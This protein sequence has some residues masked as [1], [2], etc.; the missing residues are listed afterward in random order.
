[1]ETEAVATAVAAA[2]PAPAESPAGADSVAGNGTTSVVGHKGKK[3]LRKKVDSSGR[4]KIR[5]VM[6][7]SK[8][9]SGAKD[10]QSAEEERQRRRATMAREAEARRAAQAA[11][12]ASAAEAASGPLPCPGPAQAGPAVGDF[13]VL[14]VSSGSED[15]V[16][17]TAVVVPTRLVTP[18]HAVPKATWVPPQT[19]HHLGI[20]AL[21]PFHHHGAPPGRGGGAVA[22][23]P[24]LVGQSAPARAWGTAAAPDTD[25]EIDEIIK[26][27]CHAR[28]SHIDEAENVK[29]ADGRVLVNYNHPADEDPIYLTPLLAKVIKPH[30]I[31]GLRFLWDNIVE[32]VAELDSGA[33]LGCI[34]AHAMGLGKTLQ[35]VSFVQTFCLRTHNPHRRVVIL[36]PVNTLENWVDEFKK[37]APPP[38]NV[39]LWP[40]NDQ[41]KSWK[42][43]HATIMKWRKEG[44]VLLMGY[45]M[46]RMMVQPTVREA[47]KEVTRRR[48]MGE[49]HVI[50]LEEEDTVETE[51]SNV[52]KALFSPDLVVCDE[53]HRIKN[54]GATI[55]TVLK[56]LETRRRVVLTGYPLQNN[57]EE[58]WCMVDFVR[59]NFL[60]TLAE[61]NNMF[62]IPIKNGSCY[63]STP[64]DVKLMKERA[65]VLHHNLEG[66]V[67]RRDHS[68]LKA[69]L[70]TKHE[71]VIGTRLGELQYE[72]YTDLMQR[73]R[74]G[75]VAGNLFK[76][77]TACAKIW[78]HPDL[79]HTSGKTRGKKCGD[80]FDAIAASVDMSWAKKLHPVAK[81]DITVSPKFLICYGI[82]YKAC[83]IGDKL[84]VFS[85]SLETLNVLEA[86]LA[87]M[88]IPPGPFAPAKPTKWAR[89]VSYY[90]IDGSTSASERQKLVHKFNKDGNK[91][92]LFLVSTRAGSL[93]INL[94]GA[95]RVVVMDVSW[96][97]CHD[98]QAVCRVY[99]YGQT[100][101]C[102]IYRLV[103]D[104]TMEKKIFD[105]Q[106]AKVGMS[107][108]VIDTENTERMF[109]QAD[110]KE[111]FKPY[112]I[113]PVT[114]VEHPPGVQDPLLE[115]VLTHYHSVLSTSPVRHESLLGVSDDTLS[116]KEK[117]AAIRRYA[118]DKRDAQKRQDF[119]AAFNRGIAAPAPRVP[120]LNLPVP[121]AVPAAPQP[122]SGGFARIGVPPALRTSIAPV[123]PQFITPQGAAQKTR[124]NGLVAARR[125]ATG[126][127]PVGEP[128]QVSARPASAAAPSY[129]PEFRDLSQGNWLA[130]S[131]M[132]RGKSGRAHAP[133]LPTPTYHGKDKMF[134]RSLHQLQ[135]ANASRSG[136]SRLP[137]QTPGAMLADLVRNGQK[138][139]SRATSAL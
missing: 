4:R 26:R 32:S 97:P 19:P 54:R 30:Q 12:A 44:G 134:Q 2:E 51:Q 69:S 57:L 36:V 25:K 128:L 61:F 50:D 114:K 106:V 116:E 27:D 119:F 53:G 13:E 98:A 56:K 48:P 34:L 60:G 112:V 72:L 94:V 96:N 102:Y 84:L 52:R 28:G 137:S 101:E 47:D 14:D 1:M 79:I 122:I 127:A 15:E 9:S 117:S 78:N 103:A 75:D 7:Q 99:R 125:I 31:G 113:P 82:L 73:R 5:A 93:G 64:E 111:L 71:F 104:G 35:T 120:T 138:S 6:E 85:Q 42:A 121:G 11:A 49:K 118:V 136:T 37:W 77:Y 83:E 68:I 131:A 33:G 22:P 39:A 18:R 100:K 70:C 46:F 63:D 55:S 91:C 124:V 108:R 65:Y 20:G 45:E 29:G 132:P 67:Q 115:F 21:H 43:R 126:A 81:R 41:I 90:R 88:N 139:A 110:L 130:S 10:A 135:G 40:I 87:E 105:R 92:P 23:P 109:T 58:Y 66:F 86:M 3:R 80:D 123:H 17:M 8:M 89:N 95:N 107:Q 62:T 129:V 76:T 24:P 16:E 133:G 59:P 38:D 74:R